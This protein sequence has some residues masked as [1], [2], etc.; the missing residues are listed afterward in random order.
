MDTYTE[1]ED[2]YDVDE[3]F[4]LPSLAGAGAGDIASV[5]APQTDELVAV[6]YDTADFRLA[7]NRIVLRRRRGGA[8]AG[9]HLKLPGA[10]ARTEVHRP[11]GRGDRVPPALGSLVYRTHSRYAALAG[12]TAV[13]QAGD[14]P[15]L[16]REWPG[17]GRARRRS[18]AR[19][20][21]RRSGRGR[22][23][24]GVA[25]GRDRTR[26]RRPQGAQARRTAIGGGGSEAIPPALQIRRATRRPR[27]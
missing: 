22:G 12:G 15:A 21:V 17:A 13:D 6:Y 9:W 2:K 11:L 27:R 26:R 5:G 18:G 14:L 8:D 20:A 3:N 16:C 10:G 19:R 25:R 24:F 4:V 7:R 23:A 1:I